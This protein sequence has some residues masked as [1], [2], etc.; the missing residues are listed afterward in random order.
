MTVRKDSANYALRFYDKANDRLLHR[1]PIIEFQKTMVAQVEGRIKLTFI[2][3]ET[4][5]YLTL[6]IFGWEVTD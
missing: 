3:T 5:R 1:V 4:G 6:R 2:P